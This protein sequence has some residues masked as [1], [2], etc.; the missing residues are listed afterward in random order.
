V[1]SKKFCDAPSWLLVYRTLRTRAAKLRKQSQLELYFS[2]FASSATNFG[3]SNET[4][5]ERVHIITRPFSNN[6]N[7]QLF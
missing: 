1:L 7:L 2:T 3:S 5:L 6:E 4:K